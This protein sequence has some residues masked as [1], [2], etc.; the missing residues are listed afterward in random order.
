MA[1]TLEEALGSL[2]S[3]NDHG[4]DSRILFSID[5][6]LRTI[7]VPPGTV[8][9]VYFDRNV[10]TINF[11]M[12][13]YY[14]DLDLG[15]FGIK[16]NYV[17]NDE[18]HIYIVTDKTVGESKITFTWTVDFPAYAKNGD[19]VI[20]SVCLRKTDSGG[21]V[22]KEFNTTVHTV[23]VLPGL[24]IEI[25]EA[26]EQTVKDYLVQIS[27]LASDINIKYEEIEDIYDSIKDLTVI[28]EI[29]EDS[30][31]A[32]SSGAVYDALGD[33]ETILATIVTPSNEG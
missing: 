9:G 23:N 3:S 31:N 7:T 29:I 27:N 22:T 20:F 2:E 16:I 6:D 4:S 13:R 5:N 14:H 32:V 28:D 24:E 25:D 11:E 1:D 10:Q 19:S 17:A 21:N 8:F 30:P 26:D 15:D 18:G 12:P 33:I